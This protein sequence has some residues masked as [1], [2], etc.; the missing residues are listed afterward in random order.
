MSLSADLS[1]VW[2]FSQPHLDQTDNIYRNIVTT[3]CFPSGALSSIC[4]QIRSPK[5]SPFKTYRNGS[6]TPSCTW[7]FKKIDCHGNVQPYNKYSPYMETDD[8]PI[9]FQYLSTH[10]YTIDT[11]LTRMMNESTVRINTDNANKLICI[12]RSISIV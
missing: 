4:L 5:L 10:N 1:T 7:A 11:E 3:N 8:I 12:A 2:L 9:L 6:S